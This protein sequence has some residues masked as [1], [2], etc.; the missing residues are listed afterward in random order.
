MVECIFRAVQEM[1]KKM[2]EEIARTQNISYPEQITVAEIYNVVGRILGEACKKQVGE[3]EGC[4]AEPMKEGDEI[5]MDSFILLK[6]LMEDNLISEEYYEQ[7]FEGLIK[8][9]PGLE[10]QVRQD[11]AKGLV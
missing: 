5:T 1:I 6:Q 8:M 9:K 7:I 11:R 10:E 2:K 4:S 3:R